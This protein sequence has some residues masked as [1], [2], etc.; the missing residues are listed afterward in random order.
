M[1]SVDS[2]MESN[3]VNHDIDPS[4]AEYNGSADCLPSTM[5]ENTLDEDKVVEK[6]C[7]TSLSTDEDSATESLPAPEELTEEAHDKS[8][9]SDSGLGPETLSANN[10]PVESDGE[11]INVCPSS[12]RD[13]DD[14][15]QDPNSSRP[16]K[17]LNEILQMEPSRSNLKRKHPVEED[18]DE[19]KLKKKR[20][21]V[22]DSVTVFYFPRAQGFTCVPSQ[23][24]STLGMGAQHS[25]MKKF[26]IVE[27]ANEQRRI[28]RQLLQQLRI[29]RSITGDV[30]TSSDDSDSEDEISDASESEMDLDNYYFLQPIPTRQRRALLRSAGVR[31]IDSVEKDECRTIRSSREFCGCGCKGYC[32]PDTCSCS[33]AGIKCQVDRL[34]FPCG[35]TKDNC[36]NSSGRIEFNPVRVRTHFIHTLM[37]LELEKKQ[38][39]EMKEKRDHWMNN[40][41]LNGHGFQN[42][43][44]EHLLPIANNKVDVNKC[45]GSLLR[46]ISLNSHV[47]V[48]NC[49]NNGSFTNVHYGTM[50]EGTASTLQS[51]SISF[52]NLPAREDSLDL[53]SYRETCY[54][55]EAE[56][57]LQHNHVNFPST[58]N[59]DHH[60]E[61]QFDPRF[62]DVSAF[63][64]RVNCSL[65]PIAIPSSYVPTSQ[66]HQYTHSY[67]STGF[68]EFTSAPLPVFSLYNNGS[69]EFGNGKLG[70]GTCQ[71]IQSSVQFDNLTSENFQS[72]LKE[73]QYTSLSS[74]IGANNKI[75]SFCELL[76]RRYSYDEP[77]NFQTINAE[78]SA[79]GPGESG[80]TVN[81]TTD[82]R[83]DCDEN[84][85]EIIKKS[86]VETVSA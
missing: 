79:V 4:P 24:G 83:E 12:S 46:D 38:E 71:Q 21:I 28:H 74:V 27:H 61:Y 63:S 82:S 8:D 3:T 55:D 16:M 84:F 22:F 86:I 26:S 18:C 15:N 66:S 7:H 68:N 36:G 70:E 23:G 65:A 30:A 19:P 64:S 33:Q 75:E 56:R 29:E 72:E 47:E 67:Q 35:C 11:T 54:G 43:G 57:K 53:Y 80:S 59:G 10:F 1:G 5:A 45:S 81:T 31:K 20:S 62:P 17:D 50:S 69:S 37:R 14:V 48:E 51:R 85:G 52:S 73:N 78:H 25:Q 60:Q 2:R 6:P 44:G 58:S 39:E 41:R 49:V 76:N 40:E 32:D 13:N 9:S 42:G 34:N 77:N